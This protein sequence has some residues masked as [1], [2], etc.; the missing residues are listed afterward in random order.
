ME[1]DASLNTL[2]G[3]VPEGARL[4]LIRNLIEAIGPESL[5][6]SARLTGD[7]AVPP[8]I[9][10][11]MAGLTRRSPAGQA[12][13]LVRVL[14]EDDARRALEGAQRVSFEQGRAA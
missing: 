1:H 13:W 3:S 6:E 10:S 2:A 9:E 11:L 7:T 4:G 8:T 5:P 12:R 14:G